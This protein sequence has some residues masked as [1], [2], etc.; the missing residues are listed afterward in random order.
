MSEERSTIKTYKRLLS[1]AGAYKFI[2]VLGLSASVITG[3]SR[4]GFLA[5]VGPFIDSFSQNG[6]TEAVEGKEKEK[7]KDL[8]NSMNPAEYIADK[9]GVDIDDKNQAISWQL[10]LIY[11]FGLVGFTLLNVLMKTINRYC[12]R[13]LGSYIV[14]DLRDRL[15][16]H[17][18]RQSLRFFGKSDVGHLISSINNDTAAVQRA[19]TGNLAELTRA[20]AEI[21]AV[22]VFVVIFFFIKLGMYAIPFILLAVGILFYLPVHFVARRIKVIYRKTLEKISELNS[23]MHEVFTGIRIIKAYNTEDIEQDRFAHTNRRYTK[24]VLKAARAELGV[25]GIMECMNI[26]VGVAFIIYCMTQGFGYGFLF[27]LIAV[28][29]YAYEPMKRL[30]K[31]YTQM[32]QSVA[33]ADRIFDYL[34]DDQSIQ[35]SANPTPMTEFTTSIK[36]EDVSFAYDKNSPVLKSINLEI[37]KGSVVAFV[38][39]AGSGKSTITNL[40]ARFYEVDSGSISIDGVDIREI[41]N[42]DLREHIGVVTQDTILFNCSITENIAYGDRNVDK[43]RVIEAA[44]KACAHEFIM[45]KEEQYDTIVGEKGFVLSGGQKQRISIARAFY[46]DPEILI[47]DEATSSLDNVTEHEVQ[48]ELN[49][50]MKNR[51]VLA[52]A[53]RLSTIKD[54]DVIYVL[55][56]GCIVE[57]GSHEDLMALDG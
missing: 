44:K 35:D 32:Q 47:L 31:V 25:Q 13:L 46:K 18:Q 39:H 5:N 6:E 54:A 15:F 22:I 10:A 51:T 36:L 24:A 42:A 26:V 2:L 56:D 19:V 57:F 16:N 43:D 52:I 7:E 9:L 49:I 12:M 3:L 23:R 14:R 20:P 37:P 41:K 17:I 34:D 27:T 48:Q 4:F 45:E 33:A 40:I 21:I 55:G 30:A 8:I 29:M 1:Y 11:G 38:G 53:H 28:G 50:L